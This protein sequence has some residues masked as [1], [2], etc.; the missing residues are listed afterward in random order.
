[1]ITGPVLS[2]DLTKV[3]SFDNLQE[4]INQHAEELQEYFGELAAELEVSVECARAV[5][6]FRTR[7]R[8]TPELEAELIKLHKVGTPP[9]MC[10]FG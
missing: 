10:E 7:S 9:N 4:A 1:M 2:V 5:W 6:Y 8:H 3:E